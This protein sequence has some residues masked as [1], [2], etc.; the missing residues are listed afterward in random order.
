V[1]FRTAVTGILCAFVA[2]RGAA[3]V[4]FY[5]ATNGSDT[6]SG[7]SAESPFRTIQKAAEGMKA[8]D[9]CHV[10]AGVYRE[11]VRPAASGL[12]DAP[13][14]FQPLAGESVTIAGTDPIDGWRR[15]ESGVYRA[16]VPWTFRSAHNQS[17]QVFVDGRMVHLARWPNTG[18]D[19]SLPAKSRMTRVLSKTR[20]KA[21]N[22][23]TGVFEDD[24]LEGMPDGTLTGAEIFVQ[25]NR[26]AWSW[27]F[28]GTVTGQKGKQVTFRSRNDCG[29]DGN[30]NVYPVGSRYYVFNKRAL[31]DA[32]GEWFWDKADG[33]LYLRPPPGVDLNATVVEAKRREFAFD[34]D[35]RSYITIRGF[36]LFACSVTTDRQAG[37]DGVGYKTNGAAVYPW[38]P[39]RTVAGS[40]GVVVEGLRANYLSHFTDVSGHFFLQWGQGSGIVLSGEDHVIRD[41][42]LQY[43]A[44]NGIACLGR[45]NRVVNNFIGDVDYS[46]VDCSAVNTGGAAT[47]EDHEIASNTV[48]RCGRSGITPRS[49]KCAV[50]EDAS[51]TWRARIHHNDISAFGMQDW[52][53][54]AIYT[55]GHDGRFARIDHNWLHDAHPDVD[56]EPNVG[57]FTAGGVYLDFARDFIVDHNVIWNVEWGVH[58]QNVLGGQPDN[59]ANFLCCNNTVLVKGL[60][61]P[62]P[63]YGPFGFV[64]NSPAKHVGTVIANNIVACATD[65]THYRPIDSFA[66]AEKIHNLFWDG[67]AG[68]ETDPKFLNAAQG[69]FR[70]RE[71]SAA[72]DGGAVIPAY[73]RDGVAVPAFNDPAVGAPDIGAYEIGGEAWTAGCSLKVKGEAR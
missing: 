46:A 2:A 51:N 56:D 55:A 53:V 4:D 73:T 62:L 37:G 24:A 38:R 16:K 72:Q 26:G 44:G 15:D 23:T 49:L 28:S 60:S 58:L 35:E 18:P 6:N 11:T 34:L 21:T 63:V 43:S 1:S 66:A 27:A 64:C 25:P 59:P 20:D 13:L 65:P 36:A 61:N 3:A 45:R 48:R 19:V 10:R 32:D 33:V 17:D 22:W 29:K 50:P 71:G 68:S 12:P 42:V 52:D 69:D 9:T 31:L 5:V 47:S 7:T 41:C 30:A 40:R 14:V 67:V 54:G 8:D 39:A 70:L 57:N